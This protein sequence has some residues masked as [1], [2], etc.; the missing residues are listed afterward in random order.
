MPWTPSRRSVPTQSVV[1]E[2]LEITPSSSSSQ[3]WILGTTGLRAGGGRNGPVGRLWAVSVSLLSTR[4]H[5]DG[6]APTSP[7]VHDLSPSSPRPVPRSY[8]GL[9]ERLPSV[10]AGAYVRRRSAG[11]RAVVRPALRQRTVPRPVRTVGT[12]TS[13]DLAHTRS[14]QP[15]H[16]PGDNS[17]ICR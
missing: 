4:G 16:I 10:G 6:C 7:A 14:P 1:R 15:V 3:V 12:V 2:I 13:C 8:P 17:S 11:Q 5:L 9:R